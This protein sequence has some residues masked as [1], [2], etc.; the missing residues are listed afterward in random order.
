MY[1]LYVLIIQNEKIKT[2]ESDKLNDL[3]I[4]TLCI[5]EIIMQET[6]IS[7][8]P[9]NLSSDVGYETSKLERKRAVE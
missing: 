9:L 5:S 2:K 1:C 8:N 3:G 6:R 7:V 4:I